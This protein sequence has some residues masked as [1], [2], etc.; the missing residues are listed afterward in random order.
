MES[1]TDRLNVPTNILDV[2]TNLVRMKS[3]GA[4]APCLP[5]YAND[6]CRISGPVEAWRI[7][8]SLKSGLLSE[9]TWALD[10]LTILLYDD[11]TVGFF[12]LANL[13]GLLDTIIEHFRRNLINVFGILSDSEVD[14][15]VPKKFIYGQKDEEDED[16][17]CSETLTQLCR[18]EENFSAVIA[19]DYVDEDKGFSSGVYD[20]AHGGGD[21]TIH[22]ETHFETDV[23][24]YEGRVSQNQTEPK[25]EGNT[26]ESSCENKIKNDIAWV[27][28]T[29][30]HRKESSAEELQKETKCAVKNEVVKHVNGENNKDDEKPRKLSNSSGNVNRVYNGLKSSELRRTKADSVDNESELVLEVSTDKKHR[31]EIM[32]CSVKQEI[33][34][35]GEDRIVAERSDHDRTEVKF[36]QASRDL[37]KDEDPSSALIK[38]LKAD[39]DLDVDSVSEDVEDVSNAEIC[40]LQSVESSEVECEI[41]REFPLSTLTWSQDSAIRCCTCVSNIIRSLSFIPGNDVEMARHPSLLLILGKLLLLHHKQKKGRRESVDGQYNDEPCWWH[42]CLETVREHALVTVANIAGYLDLSLLTDTVSHPLLDGLLHWIVCQSATAVD[43]LGT[44]AVTSLSPKHLVLETLAKMSVLESNVD[45]ILMSP[46]KTRLSK[47]YE[48]LVKLF[49]DKTNEVTREFALVLLSSLTQADEGIASSCSEKNLITVLVG[50]LED[51]KE[52]V[53][54]MAAHGIHPGLFHPDDMRVSMGMLRRAAGLLACIAKRTNS[55]HLI[56]YQERILALSMSRLLDI[57]VHSYLSNVL[58]NLPR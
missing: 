46:D 42:D 39:L 41:K 16:K 33:F 15:G 49:S 3:G 44:T 23:G 35:N 26:F 54:A 18:A 50:F 8:M 37:V 27:G 55:A 20:W 53:E 57:E 32:K 43:S 2:P 4:T 13:P 45:F 40:K 7:M 56:P 21:T 24:F 58:Y 47:V 10:T 25:N 52:R 30:D 29:D 1:A 12:R 14:V 38:R 6:P 5:G 28:S 34:C 31:N 36:E 11:T 19:G 22:I 48:Y 17:T 51:A 9:T